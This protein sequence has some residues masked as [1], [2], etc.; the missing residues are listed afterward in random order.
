MGLGTLRSMGLCLW[1]LLCAIVMMTA[2]AQSACC[3]QVLIHP[4]GPTAFP[5]A[6]QTH[7]PLMKA[8]LRALEN[9]ARG[10]IA[11]Y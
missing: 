7:Q 8:R 5:T 11:K 10:H 4:H 9:L 2:D 3:V 6:Q 1:A